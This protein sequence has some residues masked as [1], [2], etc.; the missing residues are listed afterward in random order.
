MPHLATESTPASV[1]DQVNRT[2]ADNR[3]PPP[4]RDDREVRVEERLASIVVRV[5]IVLIVG[6]ILFDLLIDLTC[7]G[8]EIGG[9]AAVSGIG[10]VMGGRYLRNRRDAKRRGASKDGS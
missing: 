5:G 8:S 4:S 7:P 1:L 10:A 2:L 3:S 6:I 9:A